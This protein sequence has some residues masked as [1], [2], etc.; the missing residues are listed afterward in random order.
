MRA[1]SI[2]CA[3]LAAGFLTARGA[4]DALDRLDDSLTFAAWGDRF[5]AR[6]SGTLELEGYELPQP[7]PGLIY[8][9]NHA[10]LNPRLTLFLDA[11][12]GPAVYGFVQSRA[13]RGF[14]PSDEDGQVRV[15]EYALRFTARGS[16]HFQV[17]AGKFATIVGNWVQRHDSWQNAFVTAP[18][19]YE[20]LTGIWDRYA[21]RTSGQLLAWAHVKSVPPHGSEYAEKPLRTPVVWGPDYASGIALFG[22]FGSFDAAVELKNSSLAAHPD[23]WDAGRVQWQN[24]TFSGRLGFRPNTMWNAG[25]S[26]STGTYLNPAAAPTLAPGHRLADYRETVL[27]HDLSFAWH[28][29]QVWAEI[30]AARFAIPTVAN[31]DTLAYYTEVKYQFAPGFFGALRWNQQLFGTIPADQGGRAHWGRAAWRIDL[32]SNY[33][34]T[35]HTQLKLQYSLLHEDAGGRDYSSLLAVQYLVKF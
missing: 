3:L 6:L 32:S 2:C 19:P 14:D 31:A 25:L 21:V 16:G 34:F 12:L 9:E 4:E 22:E 13:D 26:F 8:T 27:A 30:Y 33:R 20:N 5:R 24:P 28:H 23:T 7:A 1:K 17:Q 10:L 29:W 15:D 11:Q 35:P 18:L